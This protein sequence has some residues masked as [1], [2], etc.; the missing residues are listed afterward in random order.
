MNVTVSPDSTVNAGGIAGSKK[1]L[2]FFSEI[3]LISTPHRTNDCRT[4]R[5]ISSRPVIVKRRRTGLR[6]EGS[7]KKRY[8][9]SQINGKGA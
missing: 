2:V 3:C 4:D 6:S 5:I 1:K 7:V 9:G 8:S